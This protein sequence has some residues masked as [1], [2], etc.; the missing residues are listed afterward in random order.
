MLTNMAVTMAVLTVHHLPGLDVRVVADL[1]RQGVGAV[2][3]GRGQR[4]RGGGGG[5]GGGGCG[6]G[7][8]VVSATARVNRGRWFAN[9]NRDVIDEAHS[10]LL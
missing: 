9:C 7:E 6:R 4:L 2:A 8:G 10:F 3:V 5:L 1:G